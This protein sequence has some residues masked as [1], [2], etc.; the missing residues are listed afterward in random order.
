MSAVPKF[1]GVFRRRRF[2]LVVYPESCGWYNSLYDCKSSQ[3]G[4]NMY[5]IF[6]A[7]LTR[8]CSSL[9]WP[10]AMS[11]ALNTPMTTGITAKLRI[12]SNN[13]SVGLYTTLA[14]NLNRESQRS[15]LA[16]WKNQVDA[17]AS[18]MLEPC[19]NISHRRVNTCHSSSVMPILPLEQSNSELEGAWN[20]LT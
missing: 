2:D 11:S 10:I 8:N 9:I 12:A 7:L 4:K 16:H 19:L 14:S 18:L 13:S 5:R 1:H 20:T 3:Q 6:N 15:W 17:V